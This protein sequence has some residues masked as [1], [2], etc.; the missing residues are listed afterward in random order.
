MK[1]SNG[2]SFL[3]FTW[4]SA[5]CPQ[6]R[7]KNL[8]AEWK[9]LDKDDSVFDSLEELYEAIDIAAEAKP[10]WAGGSVPR[11]SHSGR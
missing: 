1:L 5:L 11:I 10:W 2:K 4:G 6:S 7:V 3:V 8:V 9:L